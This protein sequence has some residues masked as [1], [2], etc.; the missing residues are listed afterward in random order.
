M[1]S[2]LTR[3]VL[4]GSVAAALIAGAPGSVDAQPAPGASAPSDADKEAARKLVIEANAAL[5]ATQYDKAIELYQQA[6]D[7]TRHPLMLFNIAQAHRLAGRADAALTFYEQYLKDDPNGSEAAGARLR[8]EELKAAGA[9]VR[10]EL[11]KPTGTG[12]PPAV[13][14]DVPPPTGA[15]PA[16]MPAPQPGGPDRT[17]TVG[18]PG[19]TL[20]LTGIVIGGVGLASVAVGSYFGLKMMGIRSD[21][22]DDVEVGATQEEL[23]DSYLEDGNNAAR[24]ANIGFAVGGALIVGGAVTYWL[25]YKKDRAAESTAWAPVVGPGFTGIAFSGSLP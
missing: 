16:A 5:D 18:R 24:M 19:R 3:V 6:Y 4:G 15:T 14:K 10:P 9:T 25:G 17:D 7:L 2:L 1:A 20:R 8:V 13:E 23:E 22:E 12:A 21:A 11:I